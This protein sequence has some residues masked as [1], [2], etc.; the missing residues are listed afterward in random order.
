LEELKSILL[1]ASK[2]FSHLEEHARF[3]EAKTRRFGGLLQKTVKSTNSALETLEE[4]TL[5]TKEEFKVVLASIDSG[6]RA[7][8]ATAQA[9]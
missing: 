6:L 7:L 5:L 9:S 1:E 3:L 2:E 8:P 4:D